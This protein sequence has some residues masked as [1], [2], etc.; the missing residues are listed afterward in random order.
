[1]LAED[2]TAWLDGMNNPEHN[3][4]GEGMMGEA[5]V[6]MMIAFLQREKIDTS[7]FINEDGTVVGGD[8]EQG[9][10]FFGLNC[11]DCHGE[12]GTVLSFGDATEP[13]YLGTVAADNPWEFVHKSLSL[14]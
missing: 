10:D 13:E 8:L 7:A 12:D 14:R 11:A 6:Q 2:L 1:M 4:V 9:S 5:Q 3:F